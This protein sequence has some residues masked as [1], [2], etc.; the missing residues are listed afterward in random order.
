M[1]EWI[2]RSKRML[3]FQTFVSTAFR[4]G[5]RIYAHHRNAVHAAKRCAHSN[6]IIIN[7]VYAHIRTRSTCTCVHRTAHSITGE[8]MRAHG[9]LHVHAWNVFEAHAMV[10]CFRKTKFYDFFA[11]ISHIVSAIVVVV[12]RRTL[13]TFIYSHTRHGGSSRHVLDCDYAT[14]SVKQIAVKYYAPDSLTPYIRVWR[15]CEYA[16]SFER[17]YS[18]RFAF[19]CICI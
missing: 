13:P 7:L 4:L 3:S 16:S 12:L 15:I 1:V 11:Y 6:T 17:W 5:R 19:E 18:R 9:S 8:I 10:V 2:V 14:R